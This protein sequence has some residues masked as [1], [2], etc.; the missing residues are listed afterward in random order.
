MD[1]EQKVTE[2]RKTN[3]TVGNENVQRESV[4]TAQTATGAVLAKRVIWFIAGFIIVLLALR[5]ALL[6]LGANEGNGFV[7]FVYALS[8]PFAAPFFGIFSYQPAYGVSTLEVSSLVAIAIYALVAWGI[9]KL[10]TLGKTRAV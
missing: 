10:L 7:D 4:S 2:V 3:Q 5:V 6:L 1:E 8:Y 9:G